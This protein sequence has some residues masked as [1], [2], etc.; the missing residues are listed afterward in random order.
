MKKAVR[1]ERVITLMRLFSG[2]LEF[3]IEEK[4][5]PPEERV[6]HVDFGIMQIEG[7]QEKLELLKEQLKKSKN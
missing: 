7:L 2:W 1:E 3:W 4:A 5:L 6:I